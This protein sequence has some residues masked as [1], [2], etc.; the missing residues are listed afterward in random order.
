MIPG[1]PDYEASSAGEVRK[2]GQAG[3]K[4]KSVNTGGY[5]VTG[6]F[7]PGHT[8]GSPHDCCY[9]HQLVLATFCPNRYPWHFDRVAHI[10]GRTTDNRPVNLRGTN[11]Q[12]NAGNRERPK[13]GN[14]VEGA[15]RAP[16]GE[17]GKRRI[18]GPSDPP[19]EAPASRHT[20]SV[21]S[22]S[23][24][25]SAWERL[26]AP[27]E[28]KSLPRSTLSSRTAASSWPGLSSR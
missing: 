21:T 20:R 1:Y 28:A 27:R 13:G 6:L 22:R 8:P 18:P 11:A 26:R 10:N 2:V 12:L 23:K 3:V 16:V 9:V 19:E 7:P 14:P 17:G 15:S 5:E 4:K 24:T 25:S